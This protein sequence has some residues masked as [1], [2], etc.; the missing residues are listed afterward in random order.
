MAT[1]NGIQ[2]LERK[3]NDLAVRKAEL[4]RSKNSGLNSPSESRGASA[5][6]LPPLMSGGSDGGGGGGGRLRGASM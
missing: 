5:S 1:T 4:L 2:Q 3:F 6:Q